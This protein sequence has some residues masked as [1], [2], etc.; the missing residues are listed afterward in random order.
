MFIFIHDRLLRTS[1]GS[2]KRSVQFH[3]AGLEISHLIPRPLDHVL[4]PSGESHG[5]SG[6]GDGRGGDDRRQETQIS[7]SVEQS[8][9]GQE[10]SQTGRLVVASGELRE[11]IDKEI[12]GGHADAELQDSQNQLFHFQDLLFGVSVV[13]D[14]D[15]F[16][17][18]ARINFFIFP[19]E[20]SAKIIGFLPRF[21]DILKD[22]RCD[23]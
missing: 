12:S 11:V 10:S 4:V 16:R 13:C 19:M 7:F 3:K 2:G 22:L 6:Q 20:K 9:F 23:K 15:E 21:E 17:Q 1:S 5:V 8:Q 18:I 14:V